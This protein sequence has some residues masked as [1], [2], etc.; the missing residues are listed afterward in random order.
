MIARAMLTGRLGEYVE[1]HELG[2]RAGALEGWI[3]LAEFSRLSALLDRDAGRVR[4]ALG[5]AKDDQGRPVVRGTVAVAVGITCQ[6]CLEPVELELVAQINMVLVESESEAQ[7]MLP[8]VDPVVLLEDRIELV[9]L[10]EDDLILSL[11][12]DVCPDGGEECPGRPASGYPDGYPDGETGEVESPFAVL[13]HL[14]GNLR[15]H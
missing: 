15:Q 13:A 9:A 3:P 6:R 2:A 4:I 8:R 11:P 7:A 12:H 10:L 5:F 1:P 14:K